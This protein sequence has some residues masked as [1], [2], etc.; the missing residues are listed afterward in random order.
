MHFH[1]QI[2]SG[3]RHKTVA[4]LCGILPHH[5]MLVQVC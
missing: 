3:L 2:K 5:L 4:L 1:V